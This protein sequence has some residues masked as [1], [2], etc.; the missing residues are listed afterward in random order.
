MIF[1]V[2]ISTEKIHIR[3]FPINNC[4][5]PLFKIANNIQKKIGFELHLSLAF[6]YKNHHSNAFSFG[7]F[8]IPS[9]LYSFFYSVDRVCVVRSSIQFFYLFTYIFLFLTLHLQRFVSLFSFHITIFLIYIQTFSKKKI[10]FS[11]FIPNLEFYAYFSF[12]R[13]ST[14]A[15]HIKKRGRT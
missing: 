13:E 12:C 10:F 8:P 14:R 7:L 15:S 5:L 2:E 4:R 9:F 3:Y 6:L 1:A 11:S